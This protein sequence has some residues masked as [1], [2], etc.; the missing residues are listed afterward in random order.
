MIWI[1]EVFGF[2]I[3]LHI[4]LLSNVYASSCY[5]KRTRRFSFREAKGAFKMWLL[6][7][8]VLKSV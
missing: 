6:I 5:L 7:T 1:F 8:V 4:S 2:L 3:A